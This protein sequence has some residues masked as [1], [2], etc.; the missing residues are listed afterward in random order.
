[1]SLQIYE[2]EEILLTG[3]NGSGKSTLLR[4]CAGLISQFDGKRLLSPEVTV[5]YCGHQLLL[6]L[7][8][9]VLEN[10]TL[11]AQLQ[12]VG[13]DVAAIL[14]D[15]DLADIAN[16]PLRQLSQG[17]QARV[18]LCRAFLGCPRLLVLD[19]PTASLDD[20][21]VE[22]LSSQLA[23][24]KNEQADAA[25][26]IASHDLSRLGWFRSKH[27]KIERGELHTYE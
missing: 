2:G 13:D 9:S 27:L 5:G 3:A 18:A 16:T 4:I 19:E 22:L 8:L 21:T 14:Q 23:R 7:D 25:T 20:P 11:F 12:G 24:R 1:M 6:Y 15:W 26:V 17:T 10:I